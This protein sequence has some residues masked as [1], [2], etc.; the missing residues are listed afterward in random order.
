MFIITGGAGF[1]GSAM[2]AKLNSLGIRDVLVIDSLGKGEKWKNLVGK[3]YLDLVPKEAFIQQVRANAF[4]HRV[5]AVFH[6]G[7]C[8]ST[9]ELDADYLL[10]NNFYYTRDLAQWALASNIRFIYA[11]SAATYGNGSKGFLDADENTF[12]LEPLNMYGYSKHL[13]DIWALKT[14]AFQRMAGLKLFN[15]YG[16]N[17]YHK[18]SMASLVY[19]AY[20]QVIDTGKIKLFKSYRKDFAHGEQSRDFIFIKDVTDIM[21]QITHAPNVVGI[22]NLGTGRARSWNHLAHAVFAAMKLKPQIEYVDMPTEIAHKYQYHTQAD[23]AKLMSMG[24]ALK[25]TSLEDAV[26]D[27]VCNYLEKGPSYL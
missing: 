19:K 27:Y 24:I 14:G 6:L 17:E 3:D 21:W 9:T 25:F 11:S 12:K 8:S 26:N 22:Y 15:V 13:F 7:A 5:D 20:F 23:M 10:A 1:I 16:P 2:L 4:N 18:D